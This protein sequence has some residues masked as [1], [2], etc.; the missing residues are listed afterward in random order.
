MA[1]APHI[2]QEAEQARAKAAV[3]GHWLPP[4]PYPIL[5]EKTRNYLL[6]KKRK[7]GSGPTRDFHVLSTAG[8]RAI[9]LVNS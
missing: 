5:D 3:F 6:E 9:C 1:C 7:D 2:G 4:K 8:P